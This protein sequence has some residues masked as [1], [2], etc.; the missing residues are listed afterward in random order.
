MKINPNRAMLHGIA[1]GHL[2]M[3]AHHLAIG[4]HHKAAGQIE[5]GALHTSLAK[6]NL[7]LA[8]HFQGLSGGPALV[9]PEQALAGGTQ[10]D[11]LPPPSFTDP[12]GQPLG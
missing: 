8:K 7:S 2:A 5:L 3:H 1:N 12:Q 9:T 11:P 10:A 6:H 4:A